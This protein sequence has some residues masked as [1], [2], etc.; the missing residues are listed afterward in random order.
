M[1]WIHEAHYAEEME[2][3]A[4]PYLA[5][6]RKDLSAEPYLAKRRK[7]LFFPVQQKE[8]GKERLFPVQQNETE[9]APRLY[10]V[11]YTA[12]QPKGVLVISHGFTESAPKYEEL[13]FYFLQAGYHVYLPEH[14]GHGNSYRMTE[15]LSMVYVDH[16]KRYVQELLQVCHA[17]K[18]EN[19][20]LPLSL[21]AHSMGG[22]IGASAAATEPELF[23]RVVLSS[24]MIRPLTGNVPWPLAWIIAEGACLLGKGKT[25]VPGQ[26]PYQGNETFEESASTSEPRFARYH[27]IRD[28]HPE[29]HINGASYG[30]LAS[31]IR[32][33]L[34]LQ[35]RGWRS[36]KSPMLIFRAESDQ[37]VSLDA[38]KRFA[39]KIQKHRI[40]P[41]E[42]VMIPG[43]RHELYSTPDAVLQ[44]Y[45]ERILRFLSEE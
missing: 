15:D 16:W 22:G 11:C 45:M 31:A 30:W 13:A 28:A 40:V 3:T 33:S 43:T 38:L 6:R 39:E 20:G 42:Y 24:P 5:K 32:M 9:K 26:K 35:H 23:Y 17:A 44:D 29:Y 4:E 1:E 37:Y 41:C 2:K 36:M 10:V 12:D 21:F 34:F 14:M 8:T 27:A 25:Y 7:D 19:P 18:S